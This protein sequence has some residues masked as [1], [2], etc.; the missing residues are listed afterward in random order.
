MQFK[1]CIHDRAEV[2]SPG[3]RNIRNRG[4]IDSYPRS[5]PSVIRMEVSIADGGRTSH[6]LLQKVLSFGIIV[7]VT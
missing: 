6:R 2:L 3:P 4:D 5:A 7:W 1:P